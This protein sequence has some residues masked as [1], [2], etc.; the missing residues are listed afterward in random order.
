MTSLNS[1]DILFDFILVDYQTGKGEKLNLVTEDW[2]Q[3]SI[4]MDKSEQH[5]VTSR[6]RQMDMFMM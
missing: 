2:C 5:P 3:S 1:H 6:G 4:Q